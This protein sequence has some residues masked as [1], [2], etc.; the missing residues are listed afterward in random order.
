MKDKDSHTR[1]DPD[2]V[3][4]WI[5]GGDDSKYRDMPEP[6]CVLKLSWEDVV[7]KLGGR[8]NRMPTR[9]EIIEVFDD[10][11]KSIKDNEYLHEVFWDI[12]GDRA[13]DFNPEDDED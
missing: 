12:I 8:L 3:D 11:K 7:L 1:K 9:E 6:A 4:L 10:C 2:W 13:A 5:S